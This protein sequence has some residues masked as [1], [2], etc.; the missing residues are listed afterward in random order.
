MRPR[1]RRHRHTLGRHGHLHRRGRPV[2]SLL[3]RHSGRLDRAVVAR[4][5][6]RDLGD[7]LSLVRPAQLVLARVAPSLTL[8][9]PAGTSARRVPSTARAASRPSSRRR[10]PSPSRYWPGRRPSSS[11]ASPPASSTAASATWRP[12]RRQSRTPTPPGRRPR[13]STSR[14]SCPS[15]RAASS[16]PT[17]CGTTRASSGRATSSSASCSL[18]HSVRRGL[19]PLA[20]SPSRR[21]RAAH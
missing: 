11:S 21:A 19:P 18:P 17:R 4:V 1:L 12:S 20:R 14:A 15:S 16:L 13:A 8:S 10:S 5:L 6:V 2:P 9:S 7:L 3:P